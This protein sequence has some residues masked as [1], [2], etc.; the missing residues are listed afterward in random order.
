[1]M[2]EL[3]DPA[4]L[5]VNTGVGGIVSPIGLRIKMMMH[6]KI[7]IATIRKTISAE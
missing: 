1:M 3:V 5:T 6:T 2:G 4:V 7:R